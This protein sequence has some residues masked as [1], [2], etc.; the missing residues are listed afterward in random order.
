M[1]NI[2]VLIAFACG[3]ASAIGGVAIGALIA[4]RMM[5]GKSPIKTFKGKTVS[6]PAMQSDEPAILRFERKL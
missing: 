4:F 5:G 1:V 6:P 2:V 3:F